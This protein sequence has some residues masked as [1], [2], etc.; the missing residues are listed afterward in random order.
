MLHRSTRVDDPR[1]PNVANER[2][3]ARRG[4]PSQV[5]LSLPRERHQYVCMDSTG[6][7]QGVFLSTAHPL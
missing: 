1:T 4:A 5:P 3:R 6:L 2:K 7:S